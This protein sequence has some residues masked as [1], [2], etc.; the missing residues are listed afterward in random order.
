M[1][2]SQFHMC[3]FHPSASNPADNARH[4]LTHEAADLQHASK[5][6]QNQ[7]ERIHGHYTENH[8][9]SELVLREHPQHDHDNKNQ[10]RKDEAQAIPSEDEVE[11]KLDQG[12]KR[13]NDPVGQPLFFCL[14]VHTNH[15]HHLVG[16]MRMR[17]Q[18]WT[19][20]SSTRKGEALP[21][22][23]RCERSMLA[24]AQLLGK[25]ALCAMLSTTR[26]NQHQKKTNGAPE[27]KNT[28]SIHRH[29]QAPACHE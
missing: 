15:C 10:H 2:R 21:S 11:E 3:T 26:P 28:I 27:K 8:V 29:K 7:H 25:H 17:S 9:L 4:F 19:S 5:R 1:C 6:V 16:R 23:C 14:L 13:E 22:T 18:P 20:F 12:E 24:C